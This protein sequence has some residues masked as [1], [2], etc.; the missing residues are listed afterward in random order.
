MKEGQS[1][2]PQR[3][4]EDDIRS[5]NGAERAIELSK[6]PGV[7]WESEVK[8]GIRWTGRLML[9]QTLLL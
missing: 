4:I 1:P 8:N 7:S 6:K 3:S 5:K 2:R 9:E